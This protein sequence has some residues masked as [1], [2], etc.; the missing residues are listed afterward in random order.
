MKTFLNILSVLALLLF[1]LQWVAGGMADADY[2]AF[3]ALL[4]AI[5]AAGVKGS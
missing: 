4:F 5:M 3:C 2:F 1:T